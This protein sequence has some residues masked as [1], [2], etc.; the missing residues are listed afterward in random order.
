[1]CGERVCGERETRDISIN[2]SINHYFWL[3]VMTNPMFEGRIL[4]AAALA[5][6]KSGG[7]WMK[8]LKKMHG[9]LWLE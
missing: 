7:G 9:V 1:M 5:T 2:Q 8:N 6:A 4:R 3:K